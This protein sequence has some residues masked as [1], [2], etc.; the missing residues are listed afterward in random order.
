MSE[1][2]KSNSP[3]R[4]GYLRNI[5]DTL[6]SALE[7]MSVTLSVML[8]KPMTLQYPDRLERPTEE[9]LPER[10]RGFLEVEIGSCTA[11]QM[12]AKNCPI[13]CIR[14]DVVKEDKQRFLTRFDIDLSKCMYCGLCINSCPVS[15]LRFTREFEGATDDINKLIFRYIAPGDRLAPAKPKKK[16]ANAE[17]EE[18]VEEPIPVG[19]LAKEARKRADKENPGLIAK[20]IEARIQAAKAAK[21]EAAAKEAEAAKSEAAAQ[22]EAAAKEAEAAKSEAVL[23]PEVAAK[24][25]GAAQPSPAEASDKEAHDE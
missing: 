24:P 18:V 9:T 11:C 25:E 10:Y 6:H 21:A 15:G 5:W 2:P 12:C 23:K 4:R 20:A 17:T 22:S 8:R 3:A 7:G 16:S 19:T 14:I 1:T 13:D